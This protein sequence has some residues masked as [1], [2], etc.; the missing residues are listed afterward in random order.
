M[1]IWDFSG[2][3]ELILMNAWNRLPQ[4]VHQSDQEVLMESSSLVLICVTFSM[5]MVGIN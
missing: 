5:Y 4:D 2:Q 1:C 3:T